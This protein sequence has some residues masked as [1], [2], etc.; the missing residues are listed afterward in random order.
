LDV[1]EGRL[2]EPTSRAGR[3]N[4]PMPV[5]LRDHL[6]A[7]RLTADNRSLWPLFLLG[8]DVHFHH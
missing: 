2:I 6:V 4:V 7:R 5:A 1:A 8:A 3:R